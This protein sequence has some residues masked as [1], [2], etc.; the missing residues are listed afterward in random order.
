MSQKFEIRSMK[1]QHDS[2]YHQ[3]PIPQMNWVEFLEPRLQNLSSIF[4]SSYI[5]IIVIMGRIGQHA[6][7]SRFIAQYESIYP[8]KS[9][10]DW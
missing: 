8:T 9:V 10:R 7:L 3:D 5:R 2:Q 1:H 4:G 6:V